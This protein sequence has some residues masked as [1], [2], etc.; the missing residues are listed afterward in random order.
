MPY[1]NYEQVNKYKP[2]FAELRANPFY[3]ILENTDMFI[4]AS[5][6]D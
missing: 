2:D 6:A 4:M 5:P 1:I 3:T